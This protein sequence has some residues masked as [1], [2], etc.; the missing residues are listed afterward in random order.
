MPDQP[1]DPARFFDNFPRFVETDELGS[2]VDRLNARY[3][4]LIHTN[5]ELI[6]GA[7]VL[8]L[9]SHDGRFSFAALQNGAARV[10]G[11]ESEAD[12][13]QKSLANME[14]YNVP[15][16][17]YEFLAGDIFE[18]ID[19]I[20]ACDV[21]FCLGI[22]YH[23]NHHMLL[24]SK[25]AEL[26]PQTLIVDTNISQLESAA[27]ELRG[28]FNGQPLRL[29][30]SVEGYPSRAA[31]DAMLSSFAWTYDYFD[32]E[33]SGLT[34][35]SQMLD[36]GQGKRVS[37]VVDCNRQVFSKEERE[38]AV[39]LVLDNQRGRRSRGIQMTLVASRFGMERQA[40]HA[41]VRKA[42]RAAAQAADLPQTTPPGSTPK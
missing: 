4:G 31:L 5:R 17:K 9:A 32:W 23:I 30:E 25:I 35:R 42:E 10:V 1:F 33:Q 18:L 39:Q 40:L 29:G 11:I 3:V 36:Y 2:V 12:L 22:F 21:V 37:V 38:R 34:E 26:D 24:L 28:P 14:Y 27:I 7:T 8:D 20:E 13:V 15:V 6:E 41:W 19:R 16:D